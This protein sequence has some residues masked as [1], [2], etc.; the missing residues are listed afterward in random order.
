MQKPVEFWW[1]STRPDGEL[2]W[3]RV[4]ERTIERPRPD[5]FERF[6]DRPVYGNVRMEND[7]LVMR[8]FTAD[9]AAHDRVERSF[10]DAAALAQEWMLPPTMPYV[11]AVTHGDELVHVADKQRT[12]V[13][14]CGKEARRVVNVSHAEKCGECVQRAGPAGLLL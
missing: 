7:F 2:E 1:V 6:E 8:V 13:T 12:D 10:R 11:L 9:Q 3:E 14:L 4:M 5:A